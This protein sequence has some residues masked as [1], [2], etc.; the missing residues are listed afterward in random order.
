M[1]VWYFYS[2][3]STRVT[4]RDGNVVKSVCFKSPA[5]D[6]WRK[7]N[8]ECVPSGTSSNPLYRQQRSD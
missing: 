2:E 5:I 3:Y 7:I 8:D 4:T 6:S 1:V